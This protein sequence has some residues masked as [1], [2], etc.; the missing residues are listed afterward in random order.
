MDSGGPMDPGRG[1][2]ESEELGWTNSSGSGADSVPGNVDM[3]MS[4]TAS[5]TA[6]LRSSEMFSGLEDSLDRTARTHEAGGPAGLGLEPA[7]RGRESLAANL[8]ADLT[9][10]PDGAAGGNPEHEGIPPG[11]AQQARLLDIHAAG[12][13]ADRPRAR[14][15]YPSECGRGH[16]GKLALTCV[17]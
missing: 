15:G 1:R 6:Y 7:L 12:G 5:S 8:T 3:P 2:L 9:P 17:Q 4:F 14:E 13:S 16:E 10:T 11:H